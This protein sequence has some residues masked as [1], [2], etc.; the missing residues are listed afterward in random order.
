MSSHFDEQV[1]SWHA[2]FLLDVVDQGSAEARPFKAAE[3]KDSVLRIPQMTVFNPKGVTCSDKLTDNYQQISF[4]TQLCGVFCALL[5][6]CFGFLVCNF[7]VILVQSVL[8][9]TS[10]VAAAESSFR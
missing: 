10:L 1:V 2:A 8:S 3:I 4:Y 6:H 5:T 9:S 7:A